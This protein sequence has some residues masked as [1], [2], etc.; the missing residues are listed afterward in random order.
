VLAATAM[1]ALMSALRWPIGTCAPDS[2]L[3]FMQL[4]S[5]PPVLTKLGYS[6]DNPWSNA[7]DRVKAAGSVLADVLLHRRLAR[8]DSDRLEKNLVSG[9][10]C[11]SGP[12]RKRICAQ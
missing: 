9:A 6:I 12:L 11:H 4:I 7:H 3:L 2:S 10:R 8:C 1:T 5:P